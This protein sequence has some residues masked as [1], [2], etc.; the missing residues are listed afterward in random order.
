MNIVHLGPS[1]F[2]LS[3]W[4]SRWEAAPNRMVEG[5]GKP[6]KHFPGSW[7]MCKGLAAHR[8]GWCHTQAGTLEVYTEGDWVSDEKQASIS[9]PPWLVLSSCLQVPALIY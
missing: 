1:L 2:I 7:L 3:T 9:A 6:V 4:N 8:C 5:G